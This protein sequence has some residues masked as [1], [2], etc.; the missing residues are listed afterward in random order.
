MSTFVS[1]L[2]QTIFSPVPDWGYSALQHFEFELLN[3]DRPFPCTFA[4]TALKR[5]DI[6]F[7]FF[8]PGDRDASRKL[9]AILARF[10][11]E[12][13]T[14]ALRT[15]LVCFF[16]TE[17][18]DRSLAYYC[19]QFWTT[20]R[21][22][23]AHDDRPWP[24]EIPTDPDT[25]EW[26]FCFHGE[27]VFVVCSSPAHDRRAS[28]RSPWLTITFQPRSVF[29]GLG[30][31]SAHGERARTAIRKRLRNFDTV[32]VARE[33]QSYGQPECREWRQYFLPDTDTDVAVCPFS[34]ES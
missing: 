31:G 1:T 27:P 16:R 22:L 4:V 13:R 12:H 24:T 33:L 20:L 19:Q 3:H 5:G 28:R 9:A 8:D 18:T 6:R 30:P 11:E 21:A 32:D 17:S 34:T 23:R 2:P 7:G 15:S 25:S 14:I 26:E 10:I 29:D